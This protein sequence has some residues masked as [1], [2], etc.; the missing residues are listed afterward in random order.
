MFNKLKKLLSRRKSIK[1]MARDYRPCVA[2]EQAIERVK[3]G[4]YTY[5]HLCDCTFVKG[6]A[7]PGKFYEVKN[8]LVLVSSP[9]V[10]VTLARSV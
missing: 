7:I 9:G 1:Q 6:N 8:V 3:D 5:C 10:Y 2:C 4:G